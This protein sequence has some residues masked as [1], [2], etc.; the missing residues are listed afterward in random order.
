MVDHLFKTTIR[1]WDEAMRSLGAQA[2][3]KLAELD[4][5]RNLAEMIARCTSL[6]RAIDSTDVHGAVLTLTQLSLAILECPSPSSFEGQRQ[7][8]NNFEL[9]ELYLFVDSFR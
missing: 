3:R 1:H 4:L 6:I 9:S 5:E 8:V 7:K 2:L